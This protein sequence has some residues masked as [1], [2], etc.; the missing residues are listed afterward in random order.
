MHE[1]SIAE[2][3]VDIIR[4]YFE[5]KEL[6]RVYDVSVKIGAL[7]GVVPDSLEFSFAA[8]TADTPLQNARLRI[9]SVPFV[10]HCN[11]CGVTSEPDSPIAICP[12]C[13]GM[14]TQTLSGTELQV[15]EIEVQ[16]PEEAP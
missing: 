11:E 3:I 1:L 13:S 6:P 14:A 7:A 5:E 12:R 15:A 4:Q 2:S 16:E 8:I 9:V 10:I